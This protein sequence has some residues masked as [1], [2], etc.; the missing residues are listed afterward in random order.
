[1]DDLA[2]IF[3][4]WKDVLSRRRD[5]G[6]DMEVVVNCESPEVEDFNRRNETGPG[7]EGKPQHEESSAKSKR[8]RRGKEDEE[9]EAEHKEQPCL[10]VYAPRRVL[11]S[12]SGIPE[13]LADSE[14]MQKALGSD[15]PDV[16]HSDGPHGDGPNSDGPL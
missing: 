11:R 7:I 9:E 12:F 10:T 1:M 5:T 13:T 8:A 6:L 3:V 14:D 15:G 2:H 16:P 4:G